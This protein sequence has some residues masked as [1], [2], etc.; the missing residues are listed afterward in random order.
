MRVRS[1]RLF[2]GL[3]LIPLGAIPLLVEANVIDGARLTDAWKLWP[4]VLVGIGLALLIRRGRSG[5]ILIVISAL[6]LGTLGGMTLASGS[7]WLGAVGDCVVNP[8]ALQHTTNAGSFGAPASVSLELDC[9]QASVA[10]RT[11]IE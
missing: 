5:L 11:F 9:G 6:T 2:W 7:G 4:L 3:L 1:G 8:T 10:T